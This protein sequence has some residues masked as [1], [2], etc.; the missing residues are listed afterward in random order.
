MTQTLERPPLIGRHRNKALAAERRARAV[1]M[2]TAGHTYQQIAD[3]LGYANRGT[4]YRIVQQSL[5]NR[6]VQGVD[7]HRAVELARLDAQLASLWPRAMKGDV[8]AN[9]AL[10]RVHDARCRLLGLDR[11]K[12]TSGR[13]EQVQTV[14]LMENDCRLRG[15]PDHT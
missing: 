4:P 6:Q 15:C 5:A 8:G 10:L 11:A 9:L 3:A 2:A 13:C 1:E 12:V 14:V 7:E